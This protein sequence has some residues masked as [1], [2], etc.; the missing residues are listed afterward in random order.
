MKKLGF[1]RLGLTYGLTAT[2]IKGL[3]TAATA[4]FNV[5]QFQQL[6]GPSALDRHS[7]RSKGDSQFD[8]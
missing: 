2:S 3:S 8:L 7:R 5:L 1:T 6:A 4:L